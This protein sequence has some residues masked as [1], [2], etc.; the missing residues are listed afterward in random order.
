MLLCHLEGAHH[1]SCSASSYSF[2]SFLSLKLCYCFAICIST[3]FSVEVTQE[4]GIFWISV[5]LDYSAQWQRDVL[6]K[7]LHLWKIA[8]LSI[9]ALETAVYSEVSH[10]SYP[11]WYFRQPKLWSQIYTFTNYSY[12]SLTFPFW[13]ISLWIQFITIKPCDCGYY[14]CG[15]L[16]PHYVLYCWLFCCV[17]WPTECSVVFL[18]ASRISS[19]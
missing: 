13:P 17:K 5:F 12:V 1:F 2:F 3:Q 9:W 7:Q 8:F 18:D 19:L 4:L 11:S 6:F 14:S 15:F 16:L 10:F